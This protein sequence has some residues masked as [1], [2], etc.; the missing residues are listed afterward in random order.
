MRLIIA[1]SRSITSL[2]TVADAFEDSQFTW[3]DVDVLV[4]GGAAGV[5]ALAAELVTQNESITIDEYVVE[6]YLDDAPHARVA[7]LFRN[8]AM[9]ENA[10]ALFAIWDGESTG[11]ED[12][13]QKAEKHGLTVEVHRTD[14]TSLDEFF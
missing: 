5:D 9:A 13:I 14:T 1:G 6:D 10:D 8:T 12:M 7:P 11:T 3:A 4:N 2:R